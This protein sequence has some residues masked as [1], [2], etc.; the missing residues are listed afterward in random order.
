MQSRPIIADLEFQR[1][2][3]ILALGMSLIDV[4][5]ADQLLQQLHSRERPTSS[6]QPEVNRGRDDA[7]PS[8]GRK[9]KMLVRRCPTQGQH[10][11]PK[12]TAADSFNEN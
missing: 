3:V 10:Y 1:R 2:N 12:M 5:T 8:H 9:T 7:R 6:N 4:K 11:D